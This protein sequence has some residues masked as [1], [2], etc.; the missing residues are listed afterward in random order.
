M[1]KTSFLWL[2]RLLVLTMLLGLGMTSAASAQDSFA[3][4][5]QQYFAQQKSSQTAGEAQQIISDQNPLPYAVEYPVIGTESVDAKIKEAAMQL[6]TDYQTRYADAQAAAAE[7]SRPK[8]AAYLTISYTSFLTEDQLYNVVF[9]ENYGETDSAASFTKYHVYVFDLK[10][11]NPFTWEDLFRPSYK[12]KAEEYVTSYFMADE[13][14]A[15]R[16]FGG[17]QALSAGRGWYDSFTVSDSDIVFYFDKYSI[18]PASCGAPM[19]IVP[20][21]VFSGSYL[22]DPEE[23]EPEQPAADSGRVIDPNQPMVALTF[24]DGPSTGATNRILDTLEKYGVV[25]TFFDVGYRVER[26]PQVTQREQALGCEIGSHSYDHKDFSTL[27]ASQIQADHAKTNAIFQKVIGQTPTLFRPPYGSFNATVR[28][29]SPYSIV[30]WSVDTLDWKSRNA[31]S[32]LA[33]IKKEGNLDGKVILMHGIYDSTADAVETLV[34]S[35]L[36]QGYQLVTVSEM[37][38]YHIGETPVQG[39]A[40][41]Y[42]DFR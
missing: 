5:A 22:T 28:Q 29:N 16:L 2:C 13:D 3:S 41:Q 20:R 33:S 8:Q 39:K 30:I 1:K 42:S 12:E 9:T 6:V 18:L 34:P 31:D 17:T 40:Y 10:T 21:D 11:G 14:T 27:T 4:S 25:A 24:D 32:I 35:L 19:V 37:I 15:C 38:Q 36:E 26:Y 7:V 23:V